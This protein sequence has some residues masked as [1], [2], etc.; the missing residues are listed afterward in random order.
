MNQHYQHLTTAG[1]IIS[2]VAVVGA[3]AGYLPDIAAAGALIWYGIQIWDR[4]HN[5]KGQD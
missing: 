3:L 4:F 1:D 5:N 2:G